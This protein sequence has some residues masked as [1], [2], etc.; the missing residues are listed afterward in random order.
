M[1]SVGTAAPAVIGQVKASFISKCVEMLEWA[2]RELKANKKIDADWGEENIT[3]NIFVLIYES[4]KSI[5]YDIHPECE[6]PFYNQA[7]LDNKKKAKTAPRIDLVFQ[8]NWNGQRFCFFVEA[9]NLI[10]NDVLKTGRKIKTKSSSVLKRYIETGIGHYLA[11]YYP[12]GCILGYVLNGTIVGVVNM[13]N[14][15]LT[16]DGRGT[17]VLGNAWGSPP[18]M[19][20]ISQHTVTGIYIT[21]YLFDFN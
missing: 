19:S 16:Q 20:F 3:A 15:K 8:H 11:G 18:W 14:T 2:C 7:I 17:E 1:G 5:D 21:H 6:H 13:L 12:Q 10:E 9:K 4:Q